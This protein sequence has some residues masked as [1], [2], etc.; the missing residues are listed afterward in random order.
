MAT[1]SP[2]SVIVLMEMP[3]SQ[4]AMAVTAIDSGMAVSV[5]IVV[6]RFIRKT[7]STINT[8]IAPSR[9]ASTTL[10]IAR[11]MKSAWR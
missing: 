9:T 4:K 8:R 3:I 6:R 2:P 5:M 1:A 10:T 7:S 11:S